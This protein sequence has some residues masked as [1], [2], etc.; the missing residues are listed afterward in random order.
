[1]TKHNYPKDRKHGGPRPMAGRPAQLSRARSVTVWLSDE[2]IT[3]LDGHCARSGQKRSEA[4]RAL[5][6][7]A[8]KA[9][10]G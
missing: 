3:W 8:R 5:V 1:M 9:Y 7:M 2:A 4:I 10:E 6:E